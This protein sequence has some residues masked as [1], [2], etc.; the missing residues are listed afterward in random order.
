MFIDRMVNQGNIPLVERMMKLTAKRH[1]LLAENIANLSTPGYQQKDLD[2]GAFQQM[3]RDR[4]ARRRA[5]SPGTTSF[6]DLDPASLSVD[7]SGRG[8]LFHDRANRSVEALMGDMSGNAMKYNLFVEL[9]RK[10][11]GSFDNVL[12][13]RVS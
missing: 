7:G 4:A 9:L 12:R 3:L 11:Y 1:E 13:E 5:G 2:V 10:Q 6:D 8:M